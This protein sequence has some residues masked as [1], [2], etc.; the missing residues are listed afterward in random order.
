MES[1]WYS[2]RSDIVTFEFDELLATK[3]RALYQRRKGRDLFDL[4]TG[5]DDERTDPRQIVAAFR[6]YMDHEAHPVTRV[7]F[8]RNLAG[9]LGDPEFNA[10]MSA[11]LTQGYEWRLAES[12]RA[13]S[14][15]LIALLPGD[16]WEEG[17][18]A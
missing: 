16:P 12:A 9:K 11:L 18:E 15:R 17:M 5:L 7:M 4:A 13:V 3:L 14:E 10:D 6:K 1:R 2:G 8:E